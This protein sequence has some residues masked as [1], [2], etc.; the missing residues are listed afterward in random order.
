M[1]ND[2]SAQNSHHRNADASPANREGIGDLLR[3][4]NGR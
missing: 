1:S 3:I 4:D 2:L